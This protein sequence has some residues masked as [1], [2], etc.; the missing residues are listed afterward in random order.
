MYISSIYY[1]KIITIV[2]NKW[3]AVEHCTSYKICTA[4]IFFF[5]I[6][7]CTQL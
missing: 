1:N 4:N 2:N 6:K 5:K 7:D 3:N